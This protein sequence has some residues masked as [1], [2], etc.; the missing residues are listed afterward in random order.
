MLT[1]IKLW[2]SLLVKIIQS[3]AFF[4]KALGN[5]GKEVLLD[6]TVSL[7]KDFLA[8]LATK[9]TSSVLYKFETKISGKGAVRARRG[10]TLFILNKDMDDIIKIVES[11]EKSG[12][13]KQ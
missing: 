8:Q 1:D 3:G 2:K 12:L 5:L 13:V 11:L 10:F 6:L 7:A 9:A 4:G